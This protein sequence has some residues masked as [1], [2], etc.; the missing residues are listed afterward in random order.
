MALSP[1]AVCSACRA[2]ARYLVEAQS[3]DGSWRDYRLPAGHSD[4][5]VTGYTACAIAR[6]PA[7]EAQTAARSAWQFLRKATAREGG[8]SY[9]SRVPGDADSTL[10]GLRLAQALGVEGS[11]A[12]MA[13][14]RFLD[15]H[16]TADGGLATYAAT[17]PI[18]TYIGLPPTVSFSGWTQSHVCV[19]AAGANLE[20]IGARLRDFL[21]S[22]QRPDGAWAAY[23]W[24]DDEY[25]TAEAVAALAANGDD[26]AAVV[27]AGR[28]ALRRETAT[29][30]AGDFALALRLRILLRCMLPDAQAA[31]TRGFERLLARQRPDGSWQASARLRVPRPDVMDP[32]PPA[33]WRPWDGMPAGPPSL[34]RVLRDT[35]T[36]YSLDHFG[37]F[38]TATVL[39][40]LLDASDRAGTTPAHAGRGP[41]AHV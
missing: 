10:W 41:S 15:R 30:E 1:D 33:A 8:W 25:A 13:A 9:N 7:P 40:A 34:E 23:W 39:G 37:V 2:A 18:R 22:R 27:R 26:A 29:T 31:V 28:W 5:W 16:V 11:E 3:A 6:C 32:E 20:T 36:I 4:S 35:F 38:T 24:F 12:A 19:T 17:G 21:Q 14:A